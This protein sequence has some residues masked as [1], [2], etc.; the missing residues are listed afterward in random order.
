MLAVAKVL[1]AR[2]NDL[3][4]EALVEPPGRQRN[5]EQ[6]FRRA[7]CP[8]LVLQGLHQCLAEPRLLVLRVDE[9]REDLPIDQAACCDK[10]AG[11]LRNENDSDPTSLH[12]LLFGVK[13]LEERHGARRLGLRVADVNCLANQS[14]QGLDVRGTELTNLDLRRRGQAR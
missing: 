3:V 14:P 2:L 12:D 11:P 9:D 8:C 6:G 1:R 13:L 7:A 10:V 4:S 5:A